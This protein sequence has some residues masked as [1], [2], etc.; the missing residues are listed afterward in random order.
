MTRILRAWGDWLLADTPA[1]FSCPDPFLRARPKQT[2]P[3]SPIGSTHALLHKAAPV[4][5]PPFP[6]NPARGRCRRASHRAHPATLPTPR[7]S[8][9][10]WILPTVKLLPARASMP[11]PANPKRLPGRARRAE[12]RPSRGCRKSASAFRRNPSGL[13]DGLRA[14]SRRRAPGWNRCTER[15]PS[16]VFAR[17][18]RLSKVSFQPQHRGMEVGAI[19]DVGQF[20][21]IGDQQLRLAQQ[22]PSAGVA[23]EVFQSVKP[24]AAEKGGRH[25]PCAVARPGKAVGVAVAR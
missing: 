3:L 24:A 14:A 1:R 12:Y 21:G 11:G 4:P 10:W 2:L 8:A 5:S 19:V 9:R 18:L 7:R 20:V 13:P 17:S 6:A 16:T 15:P 23:G 25:A 22:R